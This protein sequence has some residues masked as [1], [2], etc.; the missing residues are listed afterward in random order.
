MLD[1][2]CNAFNETNG[3]KAATKGYVKNRVVCFS[4]GYR[5]SSRKKT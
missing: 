4:F 5:N 2:L 3:E 1:H